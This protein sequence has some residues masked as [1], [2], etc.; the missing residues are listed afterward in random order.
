MV[1]GVTDHLGENVKENI[2]KKEV[3]NKQGHAPIQYQGMEEV[4]ALGKAV[5]LRPVLL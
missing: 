2:D 4:N 5:D 3:E 1:V